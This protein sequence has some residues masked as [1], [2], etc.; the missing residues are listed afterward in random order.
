MGQSDDGQVV[1]FD[2][3]IG[4]EFDFYGADGQCF[5]LGDTVYEAVEG[6][7]GLDE[8]RICHDQHRFHELPIARVV[9]EESDPSTATGYQLTDLHDGDTWLSFGTMYH[10]TSERS[11]DALFIFDYTPKV[12]PE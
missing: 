8:V 10:D 9:I 12:L 2:D 6:S 7:D 4:E 5:K 1:D 3:L 11:Y